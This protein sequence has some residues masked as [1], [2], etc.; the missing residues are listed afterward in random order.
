MLALQ[1]IQDAS[2]YKDSLLKFV[3]DLGPTAKKIAAKKLEALQQHM[4]VDMHFDA[5]PL[6]NR[7]LR[8]PDSHA[9]GSTNDSWNAHAAAILAN[10]FLKNNK[11]G[12]GYGC[13]NS[14]ARAT[15]DIGGPSKGKMASQLDNVFPL[16]RPFQEGTSQN[17]EP[18]LGA[19]VVTGSSK[20]VHSLVWPTIVIPRAESIVGSSNSRPSLIPQ[21]RPQ[22]SRPN[23]II[24]SES[25][26]SINVSGASLLP[27]Q[28]LTH[29]IPS[30]NL[31]GQPV[32]PPHVAQSSNKPNTSLYALATTCEP[33]NFQAL[34]GS[35][36][37]NTSP[38]PMQPN[39]QQVLHQAPPYTPSTTQGF[40]NLQMQPISQMNPHAPFYQQEAQSSSILQTLSGSALNYHG[41]AASVS[42]PREV[43]TLQLSGD[44]EP[45]TN[46][47]LRL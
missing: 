34:L 10:I 14:N 42:Q 46:L 20:S 25:M 29:L 22:D 8:I 40:P 30:N 23:I 1:L 2:N 3:E 35:T 31:A 13:E 47:S 21:P 15:M 7:P 19:N 4:N 9:Q 36:N 5:P 38:Y 12:N 33:R 6:F 37:L 41:G 24:L 27:Q 44:N 18:Q 45:H 39:Q 26:S 32:I 43:T 16:P 17:H 11:Q 28:M